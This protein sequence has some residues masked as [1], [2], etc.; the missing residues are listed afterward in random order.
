MINLDS[1]NNISTMLVACRIKL[2]DFLSEIRFGLTNNT[3][4]YAIICA[5]GIIERV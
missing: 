4:R 5:I 3:M 2:N 1:K